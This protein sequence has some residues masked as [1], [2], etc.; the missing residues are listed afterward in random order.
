MH[1]T[2]HHES[3]STAPGASVTRRRRKDARP[4][5]LL[6]AG[7]AI[8]VDRGF[9]ATR[10]DDVARRA[11][12][13]KG[14]LYLYFPSK[15][16][17]FQAVIE[18]GMV[19]ALL[20]A[21]ERMA[22]HQGTAADLLHELLLGWWQQ[23]GSTALAGVSKLIISEA[24]NFPEIAD[25][26]RERVIARGRALLRQALERGIDRGEFRPLNVEAA[27]DVI[28]APLLMLA[29]SRSS[30]RLGGQQVSPEDYLETHFELLLRGLR[31]AG[32][33]A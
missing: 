30:L 18:D 3:S 21:E 24:R 31:P 29:I 33:R 7:L 15:E 8:F 26:Y 14:T 17:L 25:Y 22:A 10:L 5:E 16:A 11:G 32:E 20:A 28:I 1:S 4:S 19:A 27:I 12:V 23:I 9:A 6:A 2:T 13:A